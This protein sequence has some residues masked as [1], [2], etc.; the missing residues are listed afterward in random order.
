MRTISGEEF[1][2]IIYSDDVTEISNLVVEI[3]IPLNIDLKNVNLY[4]TFSTLEFKGKQI[5]FY[6]YKKECLHLFRFEECLFE[7][8]ILFES[9]F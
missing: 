5:R 9:D 1:Q 3:N 4:I 2:K 8:N 6:K 7:C